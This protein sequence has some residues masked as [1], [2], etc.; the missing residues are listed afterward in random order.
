M[1]KIDLK[2]TLDKNV[3]IV[4]PRFIKDYTGKE[5]F[6]PGV[7]MHHSQLLE[8]SS[9]KLMIIAR[10]KEEIVIPAEVWNA[11]T[12]TRFRWIQWMEERKNNPEFPSGMAQCMRLVLE[13]GRPLRARTEELK[14]KFGVLFK[15]R[16]I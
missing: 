1:K 13:D 7:G 9:R 12:D 8:L 16:H 3:R 10:N 4:R 11:V 6:S 5:W 2:M 15:I 14:E